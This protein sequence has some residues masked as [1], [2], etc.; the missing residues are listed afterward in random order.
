MKRFSR[1]LLDE[2][3]LTE[4][5]FKEGSVMEGLF[6][7]AVAQYLRD[8]DC[9]ID[10]INSIRS[11][12]DS[13]LFSKGS[14]KMNLDPVWDRAPGKHPKTGK[15][16][17]KDNF[18][19]S[20]EIRLKEKEVTGTF[21]K[22][23]N[24]AIAGGQSK[25]NVINLQQ[26]LNSLVAQVQGTRAHA[27]I[28]KFVKELL[29]NDVKD[30]VKLAVKADGVTGE[31]DKTQIIKGD[32]FLTITATQRGKSKD[33]KVKTPSNMKLAFS[34]KSGSKTIGN[35]SP[36]KGMNNFADHMGLSFTK[37]DLGVASKKL[38]GVKGAAEMTFYASQDM[39]KIAKVDRLKE[40]PV[41]DMQKLIDLKVDV[42]A[43]VFDAL[44]KKFI[45]HA[46][47]KKFKRTAIDIVKLGASGHDFAD[48]IDFESTHIKEL[49]LD[50]LSL[51]EDPQYQFEGKLSKDD[52]GRTKILVY[53]TS[54]GQ[55]FW[56]MRQK[57]RKGERKI[58]LEMASPS[59]D[60]NNLLYVPS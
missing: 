58:M 60:K 17:P 16:F 7:I 52:N 27:K 21:G 44:A 33:P 9:N 40:K 45:S 35:L 43:A 39:D 4:G 13:T 5:S 42:Y 37:A 56:Q 24:K 25:A 34:L 15:P 51:L 46:G 49:T 3:F 53:E 38:N 29:L 14:Y 22:A 20:L 36:W 54:T 6:A 10:E 8:G 12:V 26:K 57:Y 59:Q 48:V 2:G 32:V 18:D 11:Q 19:I 41:A 30:N 23:W 28:D 55:F 47:T 50:H 31:S 1:F